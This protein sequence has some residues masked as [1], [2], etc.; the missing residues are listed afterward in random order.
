MAL[1]SQ[2]P[3]QWKLRRTLIDASRR[4]EAEMYEALEQDRIDAL[5]K[6]T[7]TASGL[8]SLPKREIQSYIPN[9]AIAG[10]LG[11]SCGDPK[12]GKTTFMLWALG[13]LAQSKNFLDEETHAEEVL[14]VTEQSS[15]IFKEQLTKVPAHKGNKT[16]NI[17][18]LENN[19][20]LDPFS[21]Y[22]RRGIG[23]SN[24][25]YIMVTAT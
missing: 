16:P 23:Y 6:N 14:Y 3:R 25:L 20:V 24:A 7:I 5:T 18:P 17:I 15:H 9:L 12:A 2:F 19:G 13:A 21:R 1:A 11:I 22:G 10:G 8:W 4:N